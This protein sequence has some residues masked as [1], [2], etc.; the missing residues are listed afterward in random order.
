MQRSDGIRIA[1]RTERD[2]QRQQMLDGRV[3]A[4]RVRGLVSPV[5]QGRQVMR[6]ESVAHPVGEGLRPLRL[7]RVLV[8]PVEFAKVVDEAAGPDHQNVRLA[9]RGQRVA[10]GVMRRCVAPWIH[11]QRHDRNIGLWSRPLSETMRLG[12]PTAARR[13]EISAATSG[14]PRAG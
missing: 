9:Q 11:G 4:L 8:P 14:A 13:L 6:D 10:D 12:K 1:G 3:R 5:E 7:W 2:E